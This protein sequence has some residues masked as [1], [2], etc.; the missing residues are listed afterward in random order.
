MSDENINKTF[1]CMQ[2]LK[3]V[4]NSCTQANTDT[5]VMC[6]CKSKH[7]HTRYNTTQRCVLNHYEYSEH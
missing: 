2:F 4:H 7:T 1:A 3:N 6:V 5:L